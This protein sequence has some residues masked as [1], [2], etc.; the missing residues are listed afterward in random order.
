MW[1]LGSLFSVCQT[2]SK[3]WNAFGSSV[4]L[5]APATVAV[6]KTDINTLFKLI[7]LIFLLVVIIIAFIYALLIFV[8]SSTRIALTTFNENITRYAYIV[9]LFTIVKNFLIFIVAS[10]IL[11]QWS[12]PIMKILLAICAHQTGLGQYVGMI[13]GDKKKQCSGFFKTHCR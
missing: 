13:M 12:L 5:W 9:A 11:Y 1:L 8:N 3:L 6:I 10:L 7:G 2:I 4:G